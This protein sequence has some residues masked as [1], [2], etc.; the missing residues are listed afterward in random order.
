MD[1]DR[2]HH[3]ADDQLK[4]PWLTR[5]LLRRGYI[6]QA[7]IESHQLDSYYQHAPGVVGEADL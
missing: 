7:D 6:L 4:T 1:P 2:Y 3:L 5:R